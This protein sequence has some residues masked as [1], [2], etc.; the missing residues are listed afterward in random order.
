VI[1]LDEPMAALTRCVR[2]ELQADLRCDLP[3]RG[4]ARQ[5][6]QRAALDDRRRRA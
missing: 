5:L 6:G 1:L 2:A 3:S 4:A